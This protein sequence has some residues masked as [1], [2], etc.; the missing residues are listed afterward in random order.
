MKKGQLGKSYSMQEILSFLT[1]AEQIRMQQLNKRLY[2]RYVPGVLRHVN[3]KTTAI[4]WRALRKMKLRKL[5][6]GNPSHYR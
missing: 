2:R 1:E 5:N 4:E 3:G 6:L